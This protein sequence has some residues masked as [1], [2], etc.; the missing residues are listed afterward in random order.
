MFSDRLKD[1]LGIRGLRP[2]DLSRLSGINSGQISKYLSGD[3]EPKAETILVIAK[4]LGVSSDF[5]LGLSDDP[6]PSTDGEL[7]QTE[8]DIIN[9]LR[10]GDVKN[11]FLIILKDA[12]EV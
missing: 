2:I 3:A 5:L 8:R 7:T 10:Q 1:A 6:A 4:T 12:A 11:A 9:S